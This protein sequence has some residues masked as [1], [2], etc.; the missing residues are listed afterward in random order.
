[1]KSPGER[2]LVALRQPKTPPRYDEK[3]KF[4]RSGAEYFSK[5]YVAADRPRTGSGCGGRG[6]EP[7][8]AGRVLRMVPVQ[9]CD[10]FREPLRT[11]A[12]KDGVRVAL[13]ELSGQVRARRRVLGEAHYRAHVLVRRAGDQP[14]RQAEPAEKSLVDVRVDFGTGE[15]DAREA[16][17]DGVDEA[18]GVSEGKRID[19][20]VAPAHAL[21]VALV[22]KVWVDD[23]A[24]AEEAVDGVL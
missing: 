4:P 24:P 2:A 13:E 12:E 21:Q 17:A 23:G 19:E 5:V 16:E 22:G 1:M 11:A 10:R 9:P 18:V 14:F 3:T 8:G 7:R 15:A 6:E 20:H